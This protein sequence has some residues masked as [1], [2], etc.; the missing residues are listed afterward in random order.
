LVIPRK[1]LTTEAPVN[2]GRNYN[3]PKVNFIALVKLNY[4]LETHLTAHLYSF[5]SQVQL[6]SKRHGDNQ[7]GRS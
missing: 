6:K 7:Q 1:K 4:M 3:G 2:G 5:S